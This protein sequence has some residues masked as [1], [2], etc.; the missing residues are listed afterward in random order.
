MPLPRF[1]KLE[2]ERR[3]AILRAATEEF[4]GHGFDGASYNRI[5]DEAGISKGAMYYYFED[6]DDLFRTVIDEASRRLVGALEIP[7]MLPADAL[8]YWRE[9]EAIYLRMLRYLAEEPLHA[10]MCWRIIGARAQGRAH[11]AVVEFDHR[12]M[13]VTGRL[14]TLGQQVGAVRNDLP[15]DLIATIAFSMLEG[16]DRWLMGHWDEIDPEE[17][18]EVACRTI[19][20]MRRMAEPAGG[21]P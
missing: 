1:E 20:L 12:L 13:E 16:M 2:L 21:A 6:K 17:L 9:C 18:P 4:A 7:T 3:E 8:T 5:I 19:E 14:L 15:P 11:E 10:E